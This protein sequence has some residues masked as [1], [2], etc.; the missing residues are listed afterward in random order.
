MRVMIKYTFPIETGNEAIRSKKVEKVFKQIAEELK[1]EAAY[2]CPQGGERGGFLVVDMTASSQIVEIAE[3][4]LRTECQGGNDAGDGA[5]GPPARL[6]QHSSN[7]STLRVN[8]GESHL[9]LD[10]GEGGREFSSC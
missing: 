1:Q 3:R 4:F 7:S 9:H 8:T 2:F 6:V 10:W 5:G